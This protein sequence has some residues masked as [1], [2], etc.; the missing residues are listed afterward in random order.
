VDRN[1]LIWPAVVAAVVVSLMW[2]LLLSPTVG[3]LNK[4]LDSVGLPG[5]SWLDSKTGAFVAIVAV[6]VWHWTPVV[7]C[8]CTPRVLRWRPD[9]GGALSV[10]KNLFAV[11]SQSK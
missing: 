5:Q 11:C 1:V 6:D 7:S 8:S 9:Q 3:G 10:C 2:L 4:V